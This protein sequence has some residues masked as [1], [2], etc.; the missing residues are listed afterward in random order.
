MRTDFLGQQPTCSQLMACSIDQT[1]MKLYPVSELPT[2]LASGPAL[3][4]MF[5]CLL[6]D[7]DPSDQED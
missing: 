4:K 1:A 3:E 2:E 6:V 7:L 5:V